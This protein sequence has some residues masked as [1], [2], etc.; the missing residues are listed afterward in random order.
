MRMA[1]GAASVDDNN[2]VDESLTTTV[3][4]ANTGSGTTI[5]PSLSYYFHT[6]DDFLIFTNT[7][8]TYG[9]VVSLTGEN[10]TIDA[11]SGN[12]I[13]YTES[14]NV[15]YNFESGDSIYTGSHE[16][17]SSISSNGDVILYLDNGSNTITIKDIPTYKVNI[18]GSTVTRV[19]FSGNDSIYVDGSNITIDT[20]DGSQIIDTIESQATIDAESGDD[21]ISVISGSGLYIIGGDGSDSI[22]MILD[23][24]YTSSLISDLTID[25][26]AGNDTIYNGYGHNTSINGGSGGDY[27]YNSGMSTFIDGG[28]GNDSIYNTGSDAT[29]IGGAGIDTIVGNSLRSETFIHSVDTDIIYGFGSGDTVSIESGS[30]TSSVASGSDVLITTSNG[31]IVLKDTSRSNV[32]V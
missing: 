22:S 10:D 2:H 18:D 19:N 7:N 31:S 26:G 14:N 13:I 6:A 20:G 30:I 17:T 11:G 16:I 8:G 4:W 27:I 32:S 1:D 21:V 12:D 29:I 24:S 23:T 9:D 28:T 3:I 25:G 5:S 15:I